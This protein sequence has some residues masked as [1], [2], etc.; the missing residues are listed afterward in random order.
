MLTLIEVNLNSIF[1]WNTYATL[2]C[3][4]IMNAKFKTENT[5]ILPVKTRPHFSPLPPI[6]ITS[7]SFHVPRAHRNNLRQVFFVPGLS[8]AYIFEVSG[9]SSPSF[10]F[11][12]TVFCFIR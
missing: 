9:F 4:P 6:P 8:K 2:S 12:K 7:P 3:P 5:K 10:N 11:L 1:F